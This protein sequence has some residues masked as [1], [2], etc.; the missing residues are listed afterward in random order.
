MMIET[1]LPMWTDV[2]WQATAVALAA[3]TVALAA[4]HVPA[5]VRQGI[6]AV[7]LLK[8]LAPPFVYLPGGLFALLPRPSAAV[9]IDAGG[10]SL[11]GGAEFSLVP[12][13]VGLYLVGVALVIC[14][15][16]VSAVRIRRLN[17][18]ALRPSDAIRRMAAHIGNRVGLRRRVEIGISDEVDSPIAIGVV[19][20]RVLIPSALLDS[21]DRPA[22]RAVIAH[23]LA[24]H[25]RYHLMWAWVRV[26]ACAVWWWHPA[27]WMVARRLRHVQE[28][29]CD[30]DV[31]R[32]G[33]MDPDAYCDVLIRTAAV[34]A[35][36]GLSVAFGDRRHPLAERVERLLGARG[37]ARVRPLIA[38][39][40]TA[41]L[42][43]ALLPGARS[44]V[45]TTA[46]GDASPDVA[47]LT[48]VPLPAVSEPAVARPM[49]ATPVA[50]RV[51][52]DGAQP[53]FD[54]V[55]DS[56][57]SAVTDAVDRAFDRVVL[58]V[59]SDRRSAAVR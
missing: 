11:P 1:L 43:I 22:L 29:L 49:P 38:R 40:V 14:F 13:L 18:R 17:R 39:T 6:L 20:P 48:S 21:L 41:V 9:A 15:A 24:H 54:D 46:R 33:V 47:V 30:D 50:H 52:P 19:K 16:I 26:A 56:A 27:A 53:S 3:L 2:V 44:D 28:E 12:L 58:C 5:A 34:N 37:S 7:A 25:R 42:A 36:S 23:E 8:F 31:I 45:A 59:R 57:V 4:R 35:A 51:T 10:R 55:A 32:A